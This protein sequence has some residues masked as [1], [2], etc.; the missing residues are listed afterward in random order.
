MTARRAKGPAKGSEGKRARKPDL[1]RAARIQQALADKG[2]TQRELGRR[3]GVNEVSAWKIVQG[4]TTPREGTLARLCTELGI[5]PEWVLY[6]AEPKHLKPGE[7]VATTPAPLKGP[8]RHPGLN[9]W[10]EGTME[11]RAA[12][13]EERELLASFPWPSVPVRQPDEA[14]ERALDAIRSMEKAAP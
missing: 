3:I 5:R 7:K 8:L 12:T 13:P 2:W 6:G 4:K 9:E 11:G 10:L 14:Y 1:L